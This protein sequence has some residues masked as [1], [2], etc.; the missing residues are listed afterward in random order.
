MGQT[1]PNINNRKPSVVI[2]ETEYKGDLPYF[3]PVEEFPEL[4]VLI[5]NWEGIRDEV[6]R[7]E[8]EQGLLKGHKTYNTPP[9]S[10]NQSW[11]NY[12]LDNFMWRT[13]DNR[14]K[15][16]FTASVVDK[17]P[18]CTLSAISILSPGGFVKPHYVDTDGI[19]RC[20]LGLVIPDDYPVCGIR[21]GGEERGWK[22]GGLVLFTEAHLHDVWNNSSQRRYI[23]IVDIIPSFMDTTKLSLSSKVL[24]A[25]SYIF[26]ERRLGVLKKFPEWAVRP[27]YICFAWLWRFYLPVQR[28]LRFL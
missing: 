24:G 21:V 7:A 23:L 19:V 2:R 25:L 10:D 3:Y 17:I 20:H 11:S 4:D 9:I 5:D 28:K 14:K 1:K 13:H 16:P 15:F 22:E 26:L 18:N 12:Y 6:L 8:Q 27:L